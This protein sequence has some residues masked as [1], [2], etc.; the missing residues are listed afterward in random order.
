MK[1]TTEEL[2]AI[3]EGAPEGATYYLID[4]Y[5]FTEGYFKLTKDLDVLVNGISGWERVDF[6]IEL[7]GK[8]EVRYLDDIREIIKLREEV[9]AKDKRIAELDK[10]DSEMLKRVS[11]AEA[12]LLG[13]LI[14]GE[15]SSLGQKLLEKHNLEQQAL[16]IELFG[17]PFSVR[18]GYGDIVWEAAKKKTEQLRKQASEVKP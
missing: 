2:K 16:A 9:E 12:Q 1:Q 13:R 6:S 18:G 8:Y 10:R 15:S 3:S 4:Q 14:R 7:N 17:L 5:N 11:V